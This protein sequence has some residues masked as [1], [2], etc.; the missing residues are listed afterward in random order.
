MTRANCVNEEL[1]KLMAKSGCYNL[2]FGAESGNEK[3]RN[4][5]IHKNVKDQELF[6]AIKWCRKYGIHADP[7]SLIPDPWFADP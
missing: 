7:R 6:D 2:F 1:I 4:Q 5:V 3:I